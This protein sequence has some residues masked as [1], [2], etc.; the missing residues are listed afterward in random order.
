MRRNRSICLPSEMWR[1]LEEEYQVHLKKLLEKRKI[2]Y[3]Q[4]ESFS[5]FVEKIIKNGM[6]SLLI[7]EE[8]MKKLEAKYIEEKRKNKNI[9][10]SKI[11]NR[12]IKK[13]I[14]VEKWGF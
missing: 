10:L 13:G 7:D 5:K 4:Q 12:V 6:C 14:E 9:T 11:V 3:P 2:K 1:A 8:L